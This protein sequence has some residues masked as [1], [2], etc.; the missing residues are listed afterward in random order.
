MSNDFK[1]LSDILVD[2]C[3]VDL[4]QVQSGFPARTANEML[5]CMLWTLS[6]EPEA[7]R[8]FK[9]LLDEER[10]QSRWND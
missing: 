9:A 8:L 5:K 3:G 10:V 4:E 7:R 2:W 1:Q 6:Q